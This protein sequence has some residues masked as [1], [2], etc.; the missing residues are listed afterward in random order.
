MAC[1]VVTMTRWMPNTRSGASAMARTMVEQFGL[2]EIF[3]FHPRLRCCSGMIFRWPGLTSGM[4]SGTSGSMRWLRELDTTTW[5]ACAKACSI[6]VATL[7]SMDENTRCGALPGLESS[8]VRSATPAGISPSSRHAVA[9]RYFLPADRSLAPIQVRSNQGWFCKKR[10]KLWP[11]MPVPPSTPTSIL[12][13]RGWACMLVHES[14]GHVFVDL[15][16]FHQF[17]FGDA[18]LGSVGDVNAAWSEKIRLSPGAVEGWNIGGVRDDRGFKSGERAESQGR[19]REDLLQL[20]V[21]GSRSLA[22]GGGRGFAL[23]PPPG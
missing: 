23:A 8:T 22:H 20:D 4:S 12:W 7:A 3:S 10:T 17:A 9:S 16:C 1:R 6:S 2:V 11:T 19:N 13:A 15:Y 14:F 21:C 18:L 5:P